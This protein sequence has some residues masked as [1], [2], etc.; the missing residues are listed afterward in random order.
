MKRRLAGSGRESNERHD[1][2]V[3]MLAGMEIDSFAGEVA[4]LSLMLADYPNPDGWRL[5][6]GYTSHAARH[7]SIASRR[8]TASQFPVSV[9]NPSLPLR[10][11]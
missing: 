3:R 6:E 11:P 1:Y 2:F 9:R 4:R 10:P 5:I 8:L 7:G